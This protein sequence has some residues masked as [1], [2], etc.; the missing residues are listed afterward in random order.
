MRRLALILLVA[1]MVSPAA[2]ANPLTILRALAKLGSGA[3]K[4][5]KVGKAASLAK[6]LKGA[7]SAG[8]AAKAS[9]L[10]VGA[11][12]GALAADAARGFAMFGDDL[13]RTALFIGGGESG[14]LNIITRAGEQALTSPMALGSALDD[15]ARL[16]G[17]PLDLLVDPAAALRLDPSKLPADTRLFVLGA[18][19]VVRPVS[20]VDDGAGGVRAVVEDSLEQAW[21]LGQLVMDMSLSDEGWP[22][23][24]PVVVA[25][26]DGPCAPSLADQAPEL[27]LCDAASV[28]AWLD[29]HTDLAVVLLLSAGE[30]PEPLVSVAQAR[31]HDLAALTFSPLDEL[32]LVLAQARLLTE[33]PHHAPLLKVAPMA[34]SEFTPGNPAVLRGRFVSDPAALPTLQ[35]GIWV[36]HLPDE[37]VVEAEDFSRPEDKDPPLWVYVLGLVLSIPVIALMRAKGKL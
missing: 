1:L 9:K 28:R 10:A 36:V 8:A 7:A 20:L 22:A 5:A 13:S 15:A 34:S 21:D 3:G 11:T 31:G 19:D 2:E 29:H 30:D 27:S 24:E 4:V 23:P 35:S 32:S 18:D 6:G 25:V 17:K 12:A 26:T 37:E 14:A 33:D 16:G